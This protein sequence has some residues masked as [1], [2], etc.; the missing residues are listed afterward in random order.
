MKFTTQSIRNIIKFLRTGV[1]SIKR[2]GNRI[3]YAAT[4]P[5]TTFD[6]GDVNGD[7]TPLLEG[8][9]RVSGDDRV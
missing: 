7:R 1:Y 6:M 9:G 4:G 2:P 8:N 5:S 3:P